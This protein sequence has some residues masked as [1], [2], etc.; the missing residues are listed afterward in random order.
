[1]DCDAYSGIRLEPGP[2]AFYLPAEESTTG[3]EEEIFKFNFPSIVLSDAGLSSLDTLGTQ[4]DFSKEEPLDIQFS[5]D[6]LISEGIDLRQLIKVTY[7]DNGT[8]TYS[9]FTDEEEE[10][11]ETENYQRA[12]NNKKVGSS[13]NNNSKSLLKYKEFGSKLKK[14]YSCLKCSRVWEYLE[15]F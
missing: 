8:P 11:W 15:V 12:K 3:V 7:D 2:A 9:S 14:K 1:M 6:D 13:V 10:D 5:L 4:L